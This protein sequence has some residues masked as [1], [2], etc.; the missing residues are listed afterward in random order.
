MKGIRTIPIKQLS[1]QITRVAPLEVAVRFHNVSVDPVVLV[2]VFL[3]LV[4]G[5]LLMRRR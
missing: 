4:A 3:L 1:C 2:G 5:W